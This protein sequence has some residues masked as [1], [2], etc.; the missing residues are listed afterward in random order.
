MGQWCALWHQYWDAVENHPAGIPILKVKSHASEWSRWSGHQPISQSG[1]SWRPKGLKRTSTLSGLSRKSQESGVW[2]GRCRGGPLSPWTWPSS[3]RTNP[4]GCLTSRSL[5]STL[6]WR[7]ALNCLRMCLSL[8]A[9][10][11]PSNAQVPAGLRQQVP[12]FLAAHGA[13]TVASEKYP[14][15]SR[16]SRVHLTLIRRRQPRKWGED[17]WAR[18]FL[19]FRGTSC[20][21]G[22]ACRKVKLKK[23]R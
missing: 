16:C 21:E 8:G 13:H 4:S 23:R 15:S 20:S 19:W 2:P 11:A 18:I 7:S 3:T 22:K 17:C 14:L 5:A 10:R 9:G 12:A 6:N 1:C